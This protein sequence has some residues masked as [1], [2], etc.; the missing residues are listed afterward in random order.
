MNTPNQ[1]IIMADEW[2]LK[3]LGCAGHPLIRTPNLDKL[4]ARGTHFTKAYT[5]DPICVPARAAFQSGRYVH[6]IRRWSNAEPYFGEPRGWGHWLRDAGHRVV[7]VGKLHYRSSDDDNGFDTELLPLHVKDG[8]GWIPGILRRDP[9]PFDA[10]GL[11]R[12]VGRGGSDYSDYDRRIC[13]E[14]CR[15]LREEGSTSDGTPW[16][17]FVSFVSPHYPLNAPAEFFDLYNA[18]E[19]DMPYCYEKDERPDHPALQALSTWADYDKDF[20]DEAHVIEARQAYYGLC[21]YIDHLV[22]ELLESLATNGLSDSTRIIFT[23]DHGEMLGNHGMWTKMTMYEDSVGIPLIMAGPDVPR[24]KQVSTHVSLVDIAPTLMQGAGV[25]VPAGV[26]LPGTSLFDIAAADNN[27]DRTIFSEYHDGGSETGVF[28]VRWAD[29]FGDWKYVHYEGLLKPQ[30]FN[31]EDDPEEYQNLATNSYFADMRR[32]GQ[33]RLHEF[34][35]PEA[36]ND[37]AFADQEAIIASYGGH[38]GIRDNPELHFDHTP[39]SDE[40]R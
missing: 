16:H 26:D 11:A 3:A 24:N 10:S 13:D 4:A 12:D 37:Q 32:E 36:V 30:L 2:T 23:S 27:P 22:G 29:N 8:R 39:I 17:L 9:L 31:L 6:Q 7:S 20:R 25:D 38:D 40:T 5:P 21:S 33:Y 15:W 18:G 28:M 34:V 19:I 35:D 14:A 1:L